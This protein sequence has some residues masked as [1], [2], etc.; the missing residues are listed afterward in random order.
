MGY[1]QRPAKVHCGDVFVEGRY[2]ASVATTKDGTGVVNEQP[3]SGS[4]RTK[5]EHEKHMQILTP[6]PSCPF[7]TTCNDETQ[8][9][10]TIRERETQTATTL[11]LAATAKMNHNDNDPRASKMT[12]RP[13]L[14]T[15]AR[16]KGWACAEPGW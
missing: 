1:H 2:R 3:K 14:T 13:P 15:R 9:E 11:P 10:I 6:T 5:G 16:E 4:K 12:S 8:K 7:N